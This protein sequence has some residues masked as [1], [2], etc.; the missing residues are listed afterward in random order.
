[1]QKTIYVLSHY[2][3]EEF[4]GQNRVCFL[5]S[6]T[7]LDYIM[8]SLIGNG[9]YIELISASN[10]R[11]KFFYPPKKMKADESIMLH[12]I[13]GFYLN[14]KFG[15]VVANMVFRTI[16]FFYLIFKVPFSSTLLVYHSC[17]YM[18]IVYF[19][20]KIKRLKLILEVEE[21]YGNAAN[22]E[23]LSIKE[24]SYCKIAD[25]FIFPTN[26]LHEK[27]NIFKKAFVVA[28]G[29]YKVINPLVERV[30]DGKIHVVYAG[31]FDETKGG[32]AAAIAAAKFLSSNYH[33]H[34]CG[35]GTQEQIYAI[36]K[37]IK[38]IN[39][40]GKAT[41][42][43]DGLLKGKDYLCMLQRCDIGLSTQDP[44]AKFNATSFPSKI[45]SYMANGLRVVSVNI[46]AIKTSEIGDY[47]YYYNKQTGEEIAK[48]IM[49]IDLS[50]P[51][52]S[53]EI[54]SNLNNKFVVKL[55]DLIKTFNA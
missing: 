34:I 12:L 26:M 43:Y 27:V 54:I 51:Y 5:S 25:S 30:T 8:E 49:N 7:K 18:K 19:L 4:T 16:L 23:K 31:T 2:N 41:L 53:K 15:S 17:Y 33:L 1:M 10:S 3:N 29:T 35:F 37:Q 48:A 24:L 21:I 42:S 46:P 38:E 52:N 44:S 32:A 11:R 9:Y 45:L 20:K 40:L 22:N 6:M 14:S 39:E 28:H 47:L 13:P 50:T 55:G 36:Q